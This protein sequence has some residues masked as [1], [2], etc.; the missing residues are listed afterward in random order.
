MK[1]VEVFV[2]K[3]QNNPLHYVEVAFSGWFGY[4]VSRWLDVLTMPAFPFY[5]N[6][7]VDLVGVYLHLAFVVAM[8][9]HFSSDFMKVLLAASNDIMLTSRTNPFLR[10]GVPVILTIFVDTRQAVE[11]IRFHG[12]FRAPRYSTVSALMAWD[13][14]TTTDLDEVSGL[15]FIPYTYLG[16]KIF[17]GN[18]QHVSALEKIWFD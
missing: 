13:T 14:I 6:L 16:T 11:H 7:A 15:S 4:L 1:S 12:T 2:V 10:N 9:E 18:R 8:N 3:S 17:V 5:I